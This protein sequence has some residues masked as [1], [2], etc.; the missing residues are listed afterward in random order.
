[1]TPMKKNILAFGA[2]TM[3]SALVAGVVHIALMPR[4]IMRNAE[5][6]ATSVSEVDEVALR[7]PRPA[8]S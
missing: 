5:R 4:L 3:A 7:A 6:V 1:M 8:P 2:A